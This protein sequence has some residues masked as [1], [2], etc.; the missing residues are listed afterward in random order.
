M[1][2]A[3]SSGA[4]RAAYSPKVLSVVHW[5]RCSPARLL[6]R[7]SRGEARQSMERFCHAEDTRCLFRPKDIVLPNRSPSIF[8]IGRSASPRIQERS[9][10]AGILHVA[11]R[12]L[13]LAWVI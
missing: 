4:S 6:P 9:G 11:C 8:R 1:V 13:R 7:R 12:R 2:R 5:D 10:R 3:S